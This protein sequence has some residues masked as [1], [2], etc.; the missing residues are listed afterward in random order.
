[1]ARIS[2]GGKREHLG[3]FDSPEEAH[4]AY[5]AVKGSGAV[6]E[7]RVV[8]AAHT[9]DPSKPPDDIPRVRGVNGWMFKPMNS[10]PGYAFTRFQAAQLFH[11]DWLAGPSMLYDWVKDAIFEASRVA[12]VSAQTVSA[13]ALPATWAWGLHEAGRVEVG[14]LV[15]RVELLKAAGLLHEAQRIGKAALDRSDMGA[16]NRIDPDRAIET[17]VAEIQCEGLV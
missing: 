11:G 17:I 6:R 10:A 7:A 3:Y 5:L 14:E 2:A 4:G 8:N 16:E 12:N 13:L 1:M 15:R 9:A